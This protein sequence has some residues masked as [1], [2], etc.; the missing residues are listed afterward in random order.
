MTEAVRAARRATGS[1]A[2]TRPDVAGEPARQSLVTPTSHW[3]GNPPDSRSPRL[4]PTTGLHFLG[5]TRYGKEI[6]SCPV[7]QAWLS[8]SVTRSRHTTY[9][10]ETLGFNI[11]LVH[12]H[13]ESGCVTSPGRF[14]GERRPGPR[15]RG[16]E[17]FMLGVGRMTNG[18]PSSSRTESSIWQT[19]AT[20]KLRPRTA[21]AHSHA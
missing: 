11:I 16:A 9:M 5:F 2:S 17:R 6:Q 4:V 14:I 19:G 8:R 21:R 10:Q 18:A 12:A 7:S 1:W 20:K 15:C 13:A 3:S